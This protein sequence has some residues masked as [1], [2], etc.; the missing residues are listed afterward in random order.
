MRTAVNR[1]SLS[2]GGLSDGR[3]G[4]PASS[5]HRVD[6]EPPGLFVDGGFM[7]DRIRGKLNSPSDAS[8]AAG[9]QVRVEA[10]GLECQVAAIRPA[11]E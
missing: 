7:G 5:H 2:G 1:A 8:H 3:L 9:P 11:G 10:K 4:C 6:G